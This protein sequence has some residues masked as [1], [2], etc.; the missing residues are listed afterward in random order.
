MDKSAFGNQTVLKQ[1]AVNQLLKIFGT[2][3]GGVA[4]LRGAA[5]LMTPPPEHESYLSHPTTTTL[6][7]K[8]PVRRPK[9][10]PTPDSFDQTMAKGAGLG[11]AV[12][13]QV[14]NVINAIKAKALAA[15]DGVA[16]MLPDIHTSR[17]LMNTFG[18]PAALAT[19]MAGAYGGLQTA[20]AIARRRQRSVVQDSLAD[21]KAEYERELRRQF[22]NRIKGAAT[23]QPATQP[24]AQ[25]AEKQAAFED[26]KGA[27]GGSLALAY[28]LPMAVSAYSGFRLGRGHTQPK[29]LQ[30]AIELRRRALQGQAPGLYAIADNVALQ[31]L[32]ESV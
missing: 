32:D 19:G 16:N 12:S 5:H 17:P 3:F 24:A 14:S 21:A 22:S 28:G 1:E 23:E 11:S 29:A 30:K 20:D 8:I 4:A 27:L 2:T 26:L 31:D 13:A 9:P 7:I 25:P 10:R 18:M 15:R 6:P